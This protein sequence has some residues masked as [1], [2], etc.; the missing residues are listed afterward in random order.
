LRANNFTRIL[1][2]EEKALFTLRELYSS[3]GYTPYK[4]SKFEEYDLYASNKDF[5]VSDRV[6]TFND[7]DGRL[8]ALKPDVTLSIVRNTAGGGVRKVY[9][10]EN[11]YR[12]SG[13]TGQFKEIMQ[14]GLECIGNITS[15]DVLEVV[16][17]AAKSLEVISES[18]V[19]DIS[20]MGV[21]SAFLDEAGISDTAKKRLTA[22]ISEKNSH[23]LSL[24]CRELGIST[25]SAERITALVS[26][27]GDRKSVLS[28]LDAL[29]TTAA[30]RQAL[31]ELATLDRFIDSFDKTG[32]V[33][34]DF[35]VVNNMRYYNGIV[36]KGFVEGIADGVLA[37]GEYGKLLAGMGT[38]ANA[39]G[40]A[41]Y[42]D[43]LSEL[44]SEPEGN[45][46]DILLL[47]SAEDDPTAVLAYK[48]KLIAEGNRTLT[49][50][51]APDKLRCAKIIR[52]GE[53]SDKQ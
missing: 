52:F 21:V 44:D 11:V 33:R 40:F 37:G 45:D 5:L 30:S 27:Y 50:T 41:I 14:T 32:R 48:A 12:V 13:T 18:F 8:L 24:A 31:S 3:N 43:L 34:F 46:V 28:R 9:Y 26:V 49:A 7:T 2:N 51:E 53:R 35:S 17:L 19:L 42:L 6:I 22:L 15:Q 23:E 38:C 47:Y 29:C 10:N 1:K 39:I 20:H 16:L 4:M 25:E 36:F